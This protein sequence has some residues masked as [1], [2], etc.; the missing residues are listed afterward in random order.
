MDRQRRS[1]LVI[2]L[3]L[4]LG[5]GLWLAAQVTPQ[6]STWLEHFTWP[7]GLIAVGSIL[8]LAGLLAGSPDL[9]IPGCITAGIGG[10][11]YYQNLTGN[12]E[13]WAYMW[14]LLPGFAGVGEILAGLFSKGGSDRIRGGLRQILIS[15]VLFLV[16]ASLLGGFRP[17]GP[18]WPI[19][20]IAGGVF[21]LFDALLFK[22]S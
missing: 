15:L 12:W 20:I 4:I 9:A 1:H 14:A 18:Y 19:L 6:V 8:V 22:K 2:G 7:M 17:F 10:I 21:M 5:G 3:F 16:F 13:S 11:L